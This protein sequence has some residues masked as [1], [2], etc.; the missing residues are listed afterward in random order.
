VVAVAIIHFHFT[1]F[2]WL[3][4]RWWRLLEFVFSPFSPIYVCMYV[5]MILHELAKQ[6]DIA[7]EEQS[8]RWFEDGYYNWMFLCFS[9]CSAH[10]LS[11]YHDVIVSADMKYGFYRDALYQQV[12]KEFLIELRPEAGMILCTLLW[13]SPDGGSRGFLGSPQDG[14]IRAVTKNASVRKGTSRV[15][16][17]QTRKNKFMSAKF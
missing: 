8:E 6:R 4:H 2:F 12:A 3:F 10:G 1:L 15:R 11:S 5:R 17:A 13:R 16:G 14:G 9:L 7:V